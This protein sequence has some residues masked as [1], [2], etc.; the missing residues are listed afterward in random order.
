MMMSSTNAAE[1]RRATA[2]AVD[3]GLRALCA[4]ATADAA[5]GGVQTR[6]PHLS[7]MLG[8]ALLRDDDVDLAGEDEKE[9]AEGEEGEEGVLNLI[10]G[11]ARSP[12]GPPRARHRRSRHPRRIF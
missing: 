3:A 7:P 5:R 1:E 2:N 8:A 12:R 9:R 4:S 11:V 10:V 6:W